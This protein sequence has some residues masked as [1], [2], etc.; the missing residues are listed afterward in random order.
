LGWGWP[1]W[2]SVTLFSLAAK[3]SEATAM[4]YLT[5][6]LSGFVFF[7]LLAALLRP[8]WF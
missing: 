5:A 1:A 2:A 4:I 8:E 6:A 3:R 7:Y